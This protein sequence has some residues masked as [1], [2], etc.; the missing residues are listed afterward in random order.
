VIFSKARR[1]ILG[2]FVCASFRVF[3]ES[4]VPSVRRYYGEL[5]HLLVLHENGRK[6]FHEVAIVDWKTLV[7]DII[8]VNVGQ[9]MLGLGGSYVGE[10]KMCAIYVAGISEVVLLLPVS[11]PLVEEFNDMDEGKRK[12]KRVPLEVANIPAAKVFTPISRFVL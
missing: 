11:F 12:R 1:R 8:D 10:G 5:K 2:S 6:R 7:E 3:S 9:Y 4:G